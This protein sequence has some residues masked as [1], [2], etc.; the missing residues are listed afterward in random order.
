MSI[1]PALPPLDELLLG[2]LL[3]AAAARATVA[4]PA[5]AVVR[6]IVLPFV[7]QGWRLVN[8]RRLGRSQAA[9]QG[10]IGRVARVRDG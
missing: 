5:I 9:T 8:G 4:K 2:L 1:V 6:L 3:Q 7:G 10:R